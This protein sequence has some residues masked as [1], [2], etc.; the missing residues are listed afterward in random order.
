MNELM[1]EIKESMMDRYILEIPNLMLIFLFHFHF[2]Y[3]K[4]E[5]KLHFESSRLDLN[6]THPNFSLTLNINSS[7]R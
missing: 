4:V 3:W 1:K 7:I 2:F 5:E 6:N